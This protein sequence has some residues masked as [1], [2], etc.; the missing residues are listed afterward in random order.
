MESGQYNSRVTLWRRCVTDGTAG[1]MRGEF[2]NV[3][4]F[5]A[6]VK[7]RPANPII[8][9]GVQEDATVITMRVRAC[10]ATRA[11]TIADEFE[12][13]ALRYRIQAVTPYNMSTDYV[14]FTGSRILPSA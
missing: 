3:G 1:V 13:S 12:L 7:S 2:E 10:R 8:E 5:W 9:A 14:E 6:M 11:L 4:T